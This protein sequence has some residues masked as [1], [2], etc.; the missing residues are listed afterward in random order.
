MC[1]AER[2]HN[3]SYKDVLYKAVWVPSCEELAVTRCFQINTS[4]VG[5]CLSTFHFGACPV[6]FATN[7][8]MYGSTDQFSALDMLL[9]KSEND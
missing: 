7:V 9:I 5:H 3:S 2:A 4:N 6:T 1:Q 8:K